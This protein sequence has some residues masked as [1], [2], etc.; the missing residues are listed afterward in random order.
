ML[1][2]DSVVVSVLDY[3]GSSQKSSQKYFQKY[4]SPTRPQYQGF[5]STKIRNSV[6]DFCPTCT[7]SQLG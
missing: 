1:M 3:R 7:P 6:R 2:T 4:F 5:K